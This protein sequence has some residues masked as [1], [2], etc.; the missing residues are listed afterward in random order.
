MVISVFV[1]T[2]YR[3]TSVVMVVRREGNL[4]DCKQIRGLL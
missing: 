3:E 1:K 4:W 2:A